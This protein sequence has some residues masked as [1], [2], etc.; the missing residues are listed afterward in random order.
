LAANQVLLRN[1]NP[2]DGTPQALAAGNGNLFVVC[3]VFGGLGQSATHVVELDLKGNR[4]ASVDL[5]QVEDPLA[6]A[7]DAQGDLI[8]AGRDASFQGLILKL[9]PQ[10]RNTLLSKTL[11]GTIGAITVDGSGN[12]YL[13]GST[14]SAT[15]PVTAGAFQTKPPGGDNFGK[16]TYA[17]VTEISSS[18]QLIYSTYFG[19]DA[20]N[21]TTG[22]SCVGA[23]GSTLGTAIAVDP[24]GAIAVAGTSSASHLPTTNGAVATTCA[25]ASRSP[26]GFVARFQPAAAQQLQA[27]TFLNSGGVLGSSIGVTSVALDSAGGVIVAGS[28]S[29]GLPTTAG[30][31]QPSPFPIVGS[32]NS[33]GFL[34]KFNSAASAVIWG[35]Y[36]GGSAFS[37]VKTVRVD[38]NGNV[39]FTGAFVS[40]S[41]ASLPAGLTSR[42]TY[43]ARMASDAT[44]LID[45][46]QAPSGVTGQDLVITSN[47][48]FSAAGLLG[49]L[50]IETPTS[51][52]SLLAIMNAA[53]GQYSSA[54][55]RMELVTLYGLGIGPVT[56]LNGQVQN[57]GF[58]SSLGGYQVLFDS[59]SAPLLYVG[60]GQINAVVP[61]FVGPSTH[62]TVVTPAGIAD[63]PTLP[64]SAVAPGIFRDS[65]TGL[66]LALNQDGSVNSPSNP[67]KAGSI[68]T[69]FAT[70]GGATGFEDGAIVPDGVYNAP[71]AVWVVG[72][73]SFEVV[74]AGDAPG[75]V[76]GVMQ[77]NFRLPVSLPTG[78]TL[79]FSALIAGVSA[80]ESAI[81]ITTGQ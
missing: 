41:G 50:W 43:V 68:V 32:A 48:G 52:P 7:T 72:E 70:G 80:G 3:V 4:L 10:L 34:V 55:A 62:I 61:R 29:F 30:T 11:P 45:L 69:V 38:S 44:K 39:L 27:S 15:F 74:S 78:G 64:V 47:G 26:A 65:T 73:R 81:A 5:P 67:A 37:N 51:G 25:C 35:T 20:T 16:A 59:I 14:N 19:D 75:L 17:F 42:I 79:E 36:F 23:F 8:L 66:A 2:G 33:G 57:G 28:A 46:F 31:I 21:C 53:G 22:S 40:P 56:A 1:L 9:D 13:T 54:V 60:A 76:A 12:I 49:G 63:G 24:S 18:G 71:E 77:I 58:T 6:A